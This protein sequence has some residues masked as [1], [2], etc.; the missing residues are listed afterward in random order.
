M[1][2]THQVQDAAWLP[3]QRPE[4]NANISDSQQTIPILRKLPGNPLKQQLEDQAPW[5]P[6]NQH[7]TEMVA[8]LQE[9]SLFLPPTL[10]S[11]ATNLIQQKLEQFSSNSS[12][13]QSSL[14]PSVSPKPPRPSIPSARLG[15]ILKIHSSPFGSPSPTISPPMQA[16][17]MSF[18]V[19]QSQLREKEP[20]HNETVPINGQPMLSVQDVQKEQVPLK[21]STP[22]RQNSLQSAQS[23]SENEQNPYQGPVNPFFLSQPSSRRS[24]RFGNPDAASGNTPRGFNENKLNIAQSSNVNGTLHASAFVRESN[25]N[26]QMGISSYSSLVTSPSDFQSMKQV[27]IQIIS[28]INTQFIW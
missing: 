11:P 8:A 16:P 12:P 26:S 15:E 4:K 7:R 21:Y 24:S 2:P 13:L 22:R 17:K 10:S 23:D 14:P 5:T 6:R 27:S 25:S 19:L 3:V 20:E 9:N 1:Q 18:A 28:F